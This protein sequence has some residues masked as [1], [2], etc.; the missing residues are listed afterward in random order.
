MNKLLMMMLLF[1]LYACT[2]EKI[3]NDNT[4]KTVVIN[5]MGNY[6][7]KEIKIRYIPFYTIFVISYDCSNFDNDEYINEYR[8]EKI[9]RNGEKIE[10][11]YSELFA[12][13]NNII[14]NDIDVRMKL[15]IY[16]RDGSVKTCCIGQN[17]IF[18]NDKYYYLPN[19]F[20]K[21]ILEEIGQEILW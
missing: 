17:L 10:K 16:F 12:L 8:S 7:I 5:K 20:K 2:D 13:E 19:S 1:V 3:K 15:F 6:E 9:I 4:E 14:S 11:I 21:Y 18:Y